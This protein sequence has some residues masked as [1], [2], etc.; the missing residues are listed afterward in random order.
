MASK[1]GI[2]IPK[3]G[4]IWRVQWCNLTV[5]VLNVEYAL[6]PHGEHVP[7]G[8]VKYHVCGTNRTASRGLQQFLRKFI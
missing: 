2:R 6:S 5:E 8:V 1:E 4:E 3:V 7:Y